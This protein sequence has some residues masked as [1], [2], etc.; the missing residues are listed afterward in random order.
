MG[1]EACTQSVCDL[2]LKFGEDRGGQAK[3]DVM[4]VIKFSFPLTI[5]R[6]ARLVLHY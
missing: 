1:V 6:V 3:E 2:A 5:R 4:V